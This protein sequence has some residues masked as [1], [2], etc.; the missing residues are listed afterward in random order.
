M[1]QRLKVVILETTEEHTEP[2]RKFEMVIPT[3][4]PES[5]VKLAIEEVK[6]MGYKVILNHEG[7]CCEYVSSSFDEDYIA[8]TVEP[9][10]LIS[11]ELG[12]YTGPWTS[13]RIH[14]QQ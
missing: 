5:A 14:R 2:I 3:N 13:G 11:E 9:E 4:E 7:G 10:N 1:E 12:I 8:I 6:R